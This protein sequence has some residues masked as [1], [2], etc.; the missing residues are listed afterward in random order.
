MSITLTKGNIF[1]SKQ[2]TIVNTVNC[3][4]VMGAGIA[5]ECR[6][7]Y[8][9]MFERYVQLC[10][11]GQIDIGKLWIYKADRWILNFPTKKHWKYP[12][13]IEYLNAGLEKF[14]TTYRERGIKSI[15][16]PLLGANKGGIPAADS[17]AVMHRYLDGL[18]ISIEVYEYDPSAQDDLFVATKKWLLAKCVSETAQIT[19][20]RPQYVKKVMEALEQP[21][22]VQLNQLAKI[23]GIGIKTMESIFRASKLSDSQSES[24]SAS[25]QSTLPL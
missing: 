22:I 12:S 15:A 9:G 24:G 2:Q 18:D 1:T 13:K 3:V 25:G 21:N 8:P 4:G 16:F 19:G 14:V 17:L 23:K 5:L 20:I 6:L 11:A 10:G 7:R